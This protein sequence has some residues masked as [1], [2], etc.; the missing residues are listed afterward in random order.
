MAV[1]RYTVCHAK[2]NEQKKK[3]PSRAIIMGVIFQP[4]S[5]KYLRNLLPRLLSSERWE[6]N[7]EK[8]SQEHQALK[9]GPS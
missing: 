6:A 8:A 1:I 2:Q 5:K 4:I 3:K 9:Q 7:M